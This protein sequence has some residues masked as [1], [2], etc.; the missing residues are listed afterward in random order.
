MIDLALTG[1][2]I[3]DNELDEALQELDILFNTENTELI[4]Y[5][6]FGTN[7]EQFLWEVT[8][9]VEDVKRYIYEVLAQTYYCQKLNVTVNVELMEGEYRLIYNV[10]IDIQDPITKTIKTRLYQFR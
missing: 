9:A 6:E 4:G 5:P 10:K 3:I 1:D 2:I 8:P 7:F